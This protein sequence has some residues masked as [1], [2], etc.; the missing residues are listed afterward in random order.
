M[1]TEELSTA[2]DYAEAFFATLSMSKRIS[3]KA[4]WRSAIIT[5]TLQ[6][7]RV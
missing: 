6:V 4:Q 3:G 2:S 5:S 1:Q 7:Q